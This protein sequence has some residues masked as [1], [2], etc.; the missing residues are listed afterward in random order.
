MLE[1]TSSHV[2]DGVVSW[3]LRTL[4][5]VS[6]SAKTQCPERWSACLD[7]ASAGGG[8]VVLLVVFFLWRAPP[9]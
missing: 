2:F 9:C 1:D 3:V 5:K 8:V 4:K 7:G 6:A